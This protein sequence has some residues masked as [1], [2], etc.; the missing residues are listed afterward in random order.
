MLS[1]LQEQRHEDQS[2]AGQKDQIAPKCTEKTEEQKYLTVANQKKNVNRSTFL[3]AVS[4]GIGLVCIWFMIR[5]STPQ[6]T[7]AATVSEEEAQIEMAIAKLTG[8]ESESLNRMDEEQIVKKFY[9]FSDVQQVKREDLMKN[10]FSYNLSLTNLPEKSDIEEGNPEAGG[11]LTEQQLMQQINNMQLL[12]IIKLHEG[13]CCMLDDK[14]LHEGD[15]VRGFKVRQIGDN[16]VKLEQKS[17]EMVL[18]LPE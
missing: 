15:S 12:S 6:I 7:S 1:F 4:F 14:I 5:Q 9:E 10:P 18:K 16:F 3:L 11:E 13:N 8:G 17:V 2:L